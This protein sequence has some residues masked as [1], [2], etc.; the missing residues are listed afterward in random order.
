MLITEEVYLQDQLAKNSGNT[1][2]IDDIFGIHD[3]DRNG[4]PLN[5]YIIGGQPMMPSMENIDIEIENK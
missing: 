4:R 2:F 3:T 1:G 5:A